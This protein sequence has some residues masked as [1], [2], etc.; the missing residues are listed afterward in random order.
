MSWLWSEE[1]RALAVELF[2]KAELFEE[3]VAV[4]NREDFVDVLVFGFVDAGLDELFA[5]AF[6][7]EFGVYD[8]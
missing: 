7:L 5:Y 4:G 6:A 8:E 2:A 1:E 3:V